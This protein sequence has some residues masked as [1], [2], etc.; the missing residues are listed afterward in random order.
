MDKKILA[1]ELLKACGG[2]E[3]I[4]TVFENNTAMMKDMLKS[5]IPSHHHSILEKLMTAINEKAVTNYQGLIDEMAKVQAEVYTEEELLVSIEYW[6]SPVGQSMRI[7]M[8]VATVLS[9][10]AGERWAVKMAE[11]M[12]D[13]FGKL[14]VEAKAADEMMRYDHFERQAESK[15]A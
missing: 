6:K 3:T 7:K 15:T 9:S 8:P 12:K 2:E 5:F 11:E 4:R 13:V 10:Q 1:M 14:D